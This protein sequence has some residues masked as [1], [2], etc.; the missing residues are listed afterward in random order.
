[1]DQIC[2]DPQDKLLPTP[3]PLG[4]TVNKTPSPHRTKKCLW[5]TTPRIISETALSFLTLLYQ[6]YY[7]SCIALFSWSLVQQSGCSGSVSNSCRWGE[8]HYTPTAP[9][10]MQV[11]LGHGSY[12]ITFRCVLQC[13]FHPP[14]EKIWLFLAFYSAVTLQG[15]FATMIKLQTRT[16]LEKYPHS[17][18]D[19]ADILP[20]SGWS[21]CKVN[22]WAWAECSWKGTLIRVNMLYV[23][24]YVCTVHK[25]CSRNYPGGGWAAGTFLSCGGRVFC[26]QCVRGVGG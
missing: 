23:C 1:M 21:L 26:W 24:M 14:G 2:L 10:L 16:L 3:P 22:R 25:G 11:P 7:H 4:H 13:S 12:G 20:V 8:A 17:G 18:D 15:G 9:F 5:P 19:P 6:C